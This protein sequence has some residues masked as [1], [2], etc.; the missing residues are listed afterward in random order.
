MVIAQFLLAIVALFDKFIITAKKVE[1]P[2][3]FA[4]YVSAL[5]IFSLLYYVLDFLPFRIDG[6]DFPSIANI[7]RPD[8]AM[9][10]MSL[11]AGITFFQ[12]LVSL[13]SA[14]RE[15]DASD[16]VPVVGSISAIATFLLSYLILGH[17]LSTSF[18]AGFVL[19]V[20]GTFLISR[21]RLKK[22]VVLMCT[23]AGVMFAFNATM[24]KSMFLVSSFDHAFFWSRMGTIAVVLTLLLIPRYFKKITANTK[25]SG[26]EGGI[27]VIS[28]TAIAGL[29]A[30]LTLKAIEYG[31][32]ALVQALGG[33]QFVFLAVISFTL[34]NLTPRELGENNSFKDIVQKAFAILLILFGFFYLFV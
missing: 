8:A 30:I 17:V 10:A 23:H 19:L 21:F 31:S 14:F 13:Y 26:A 11:V 4:F 24:M 27:W 12:A 6:F 16:V 22:D 9:I 32:V 25:K 1:K 18:L 29:S 7:G 3:V 15:A 34:G 2:F 5:T 28:K 33:L 20:A